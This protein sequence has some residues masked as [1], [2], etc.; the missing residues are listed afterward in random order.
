MKLD[1]SKIKANTEPPAAETAEDKEFINMMPWSQEGCKERMEEINKA[2]KDVSELAMSGK[3]A[4]ALPNGKHSLF[5]S[6]VG[7][8]F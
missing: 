8:R 3:R 4:C 7:P 6:S 5:D 1:A 2:V